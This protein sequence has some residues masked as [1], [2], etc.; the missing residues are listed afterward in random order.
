M[1]M[2]SALLD[3]AAVFL[4][5]GSTMPGYAQLSDGTEREVTII[6]AFEAVGACSRGLMS[7][8]DVDEIERSICPGE[9]ACGGMNTANTMASAAAALGTWRPGNACPP[10]AA[11]A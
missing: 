5:A 7:R 6:D 9:G 3:L 4:Y 1:R 8:A 10:G 11:P 2:S